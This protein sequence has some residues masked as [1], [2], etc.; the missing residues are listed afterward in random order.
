MKMSEF[1]NL[2]GTETIIDYSF[3]R[4]VQVWSMQNFY[5]DEDTGEVKHNR[6]D[7]IIDNFVR[8]ARN[9]RYGTRKDATH[10]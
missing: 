1:V 3:D 5:I 6:L 10:G 8:Y 9:P 4:E 2:V 7:L